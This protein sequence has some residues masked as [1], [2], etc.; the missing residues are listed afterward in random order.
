MVVV[1]EVAQGG[2]GERAE[3]LVEEHRRER[4]QAIGAVVDAC[5]ERPP[6]APHEDGV[7][8]ARTVL[9]P[10]Q[11]RNTAVAPTPAAIFAA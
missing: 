11:A 3:R 1:L 5:R 10:Q 9:W 4:E 8:V 7:E 6:E 2:H